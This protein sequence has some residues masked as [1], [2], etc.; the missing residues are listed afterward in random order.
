MCHWPRSVRWCPSYWSFVIAILDVPI[1]KEN[2]GPINRFG[3]SRFRRLKLPLNVRISRTVCEDMYHLRVF[4]Q[5]DPLGDP[6]VIIN[7]Y[8]CVLLFHLEPPTKCSQQRSTARSQLPSVI[9]DPSKPCYATY[10]SQTARRPMMALTMTPQ[11]FENL[12]RSDRTGC[13]LDQC[14]D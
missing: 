11:R 2:D 3:F 4:Y 10:R 12:R 7:A 6:R 13:I 14:E 1:A 8:N 9:C 5:I